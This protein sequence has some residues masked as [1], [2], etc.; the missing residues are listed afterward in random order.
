MK[1][2]AIDWLQGKIHGPLLRCVIISHRRLWFV[3]GC[4]K[5]NKEIA[6]WRQA[7]QDVIDRAP[8]MDPETYNARMQW[9]RDIDLDAA[10]WRDRPYY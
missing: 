3:G 6:D 5:C 7:L 4:P 8:K 9:H 1:T 10:F 2:D